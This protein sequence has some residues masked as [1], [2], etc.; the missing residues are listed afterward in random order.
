MPLSVLYRPHITTCCKAVC[1]SSS[2]ITIRGPADAPHLYFVCARDLLFRHPFNE[3][4]AETQLFA[5]NS[6][7][8]AELTFF[9]RC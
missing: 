1:D 5:S 4:I 9:P 2:G 7:P 8:T 6:G 3:A